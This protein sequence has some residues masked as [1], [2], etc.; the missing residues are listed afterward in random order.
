MVDESN[1]SGSPATSVAD[2]PEGNNLE[3]Y[4]KKHGA[5]SWRE[6]LARMHDVCFALEKANCVYGDITIRSFNVITGTKDSIT[7]EMKK[8]FPH[9]QAASEQEGFVSFPDEAYFSPEKCLDKSVDRRS[10]VYSLGCVMYHMMT[11]SPPFTQRDQEKLKEAQAIDY[12]LPPGRRS[13]RQFIPD[14]V[15]TLIVRCLE[16]DPAKRFKNA[17]ELRANIGQTL[18]LEEDP[19]DAIVRSPKFTEFFQRKRQVF[20]GVLGLVLITGLLGLSALVTT[21]GDDFARMIERTSARHR[22][23]WFLNLEH[24]PMYVAQAE[25]E[26]GR[27]EPDKDKNP[28]ELKVKDEDVLLFATTKRTTIKDA[29]E[30]AI[31]RKLILF[32]VNLIGADL[33][34]AI[35]PGANM[36]QAFLIN[37]NLDGADLSGDLLKQADFSLAS[38]KGAKLASSNI[39]RGIFRQANLEG[40][41]FSRSALL[42]CDFREAKLHGANLSNTYLLNS[43][44]T[45]AD[46]T[47]ANFDGS[48]MTEDCAKMAKLTAKQRAKVTIV[49]G[50]KTAH[51]VVRPLGV[52]EPKG[53]DV[54][55]QHPLIK[56][57]QNP[58]NRPLDGGSTYGLNVPADQKIGLDIKI[59]KNGNPIPVENPPP[60]KNQRQAPGVT[61]APPGPTA[62][63]PNN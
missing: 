19:D 36:E 57:Q 44:F 4:L 52:A 32:K 60:R 58:F 21:S 29:V 56:N 63:P 6:C 28:I 1:K 39:E 41:D 47:D 38:M 2:T 35:I 18:Q 12:A 50:P 13:Q 62:V 49:V 24:G 9:K 46:I 3:N 54:Q 25:F 27:M 23:R 14:E 42:D 45:G 11:G 61:A 8:V 10:D 55:V 48:K 53:M 59:D 22:N 43:D 20:I 26:N 40:A 33:K 16:K 30:E 15:D 5:M 7:V 37:S 17:A 34:G 31:K 51:T